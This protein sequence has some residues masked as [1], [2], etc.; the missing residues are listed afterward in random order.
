MSTPA[1]VPIADSRAAAEAAGPSPAASRPAAEGPRIYNLFPTLFGDVD[2]WT[3]ELPRIARMGFNWVYLNPVH[4]PGFSGSLYA[5]KDPS[6]LND[7]F[8]VDDGRSDE[9][10]LSDFFAAAAELD[11]KVML[12]LVVNHAS[13]DAVLV[14]RHP[15]WFRRDA[16][17]TLRSPR[18]VNPADPA[19]VTVWGDLA[20][21]DYDRPESRDG[22]I[23]YWAEWVKHQVSLG[24]KGFRC[25][26]A[27]QVPAGVWRALAE[28]ARAVDPDVRFFA[29]TLGCTPDQV[30]AL[31]DAGFDYLFNSA[32]WWDL[33][34]DWF[35]DQYELYRHIAPTIAFPESHDTERLAAE[36][37]DAD[38]HRLVAMA[39]MRYLLSAAISGG[40]MVPAGFEYGFTEKL[41]VVGTRPDGW[42]AGTA[43]PRLDL[44]GFIGEVNAMKAALPALN[45]EGPVRRVAGVAPPVLALLRQDP[46][47]GETA[48]IVANPDE[49]AWHGLDA[50]PLLAAADGG[51]LQDVTPG[52]APLSLD[53]GAPVLLEPLE[54]RVFRGRPAPRRQPPAPADSLARLQVLAEHR[55][56]IED[57]FPTVD[58]GRFPVKRVVGETLEV[59]ADIFAD[60]HD[61]VAAC[62]QLRADGEA[63]WQEAPMTLVDN[64]RWVGR[65]PLVRNAR[66]VFRIEAW[67]DLWATWRGDFVKKRDAGR[68]V[69]L[70]LIEG[71]ALL[72]KAVAQAE[73][74]G[75]ATLLAHL[76]HLAG[77]P[78]PDRDRQAAIL[79][80]DTLAA[81]MGRF[82]PRTNRSGSPGYDVVV[83]RP[84][85]RFASW[86][87]LFPRSMSDDP[88]RHG[89]F[90]DVIA[91]LPYVRDMG[92]DVLYFPP[93]HPIGRTNRKG[94]NNSLTAG[95]DDPGS[96]YAIGSDAG[97]H[98]AIH[99]ELGT[100]DDFRRLVRAAKEHGLEI[101]LDFAIQCS[102]DHPWIK[103]HPEWFD[104]RPDGTIKFAENPPKKYEDIV[105]VHF[106]RDAIPDLWFALRDVVLFWVEQGVK[107]FRVDNPHT[108]PLPF[109]EWMIREVQ[110]R[111]PDTI[112]L[113]EAFTRP[114]MMKRLAKLGFTQ[115]YTYFTWRRYK[116][117]L[118]DYLT[119]LTHGPA[120]EFY[121]PNFFVNTPDINPPYLHSG[122]P[123][124]FKVRAVLAATLSSL[125][126]MYSGFELCEGRALPGKEEYLDSEKYEIRAWNWNDPRNIRDD[127]A[128]LNRIRRDH[129]ALQQLANL[130][131][132][133]AWHDDVLYYS[134]RTPGRDE[135][136]LVAVNLNPDR[137]AQHVSIEVP[138]WLFGLPDDA[139]VQVEDLLGGGRWFW[140]GKWQTVTLDPAVNPAAIWRV[141]KPAAS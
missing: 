109:W 94:R 138:V 123:A 108:K 84:A 40:V 134:K 23:R 133:N 65:L 5:I 56:A 97:G 41:D 69:S 20:E 31:A 62:L 78:D 127:V 115:S 70:E 140:Y 36:L 110:D 76:D 67:R 58:G 71:R 124:M 11:L 75:R 44:S 30:L 54:L 16:D 113:S 50:G 74:R 19:D 132:H 103:E 22:L 7:R 60:G 48:L 121:R 91:K 135:L 45:R 9:Q 8:R 80:G 52:R 28:A 120:R 136:V 105:N 57:V 139:A 35:L 106:Y 14:E 24:A 32:R 112:F 87:E 29:E 4:Y 3:R 81:D 2:A 47:S 46:A 61:R 96:P 37:G 130:T 102:P 83:D 86:Y 116:Q 68:D 82:G 15:D 114:K 18:A 141:A 63:G 38:P 12:D 77:V 49:A 55:V 122:N 119:E 126:G 42:R 89:T 128:R 33:R 73:G 93:I 107:T 90:D 118:T 131:F 79:L 95:P 104:W 101:A 98:D 125:W 53:P 17:G 21:F 51:I 100:L 27:Y 1:R 111:H 59:W 25:D 43:R 39:R 137:A 92:F 88:H 26:A 64:D 129:P 66:H 72:E 6:R 13:K 34:D 85:A 10:Q 99:P 117:E